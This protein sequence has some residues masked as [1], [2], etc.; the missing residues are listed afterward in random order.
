[1]ENYPDDRLYYEQHEWVKMINENEALVGISFYAQDSL[2]DIVYLSE[3]EIGR[4]V[5]KG[6]EIAEIESVKA[7]SQ[8]YSPVSGTIVEV[9]REVIEN[10]EIINQDPYEQGWIFK[11][12]LS[13]LAELEGLMDAASYKKF[14]EEG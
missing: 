11:I 3:P 7:V 2:G 12:E 1:M 13:D 5:K 6:E 9:N 8:I 10:P 14:V 4:E